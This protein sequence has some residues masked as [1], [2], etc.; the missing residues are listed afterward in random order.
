MDRKSIAVLAVSLLTS[1]GGVVLA[2][3]TWASLQTPAAVGG[4]LLAIAGSLA[5]A[6]GVKAGG[7]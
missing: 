7:S 5:A 1:I 3:P 4:F 2:A 6:F